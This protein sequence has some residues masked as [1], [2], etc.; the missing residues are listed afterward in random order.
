MSYLSKFALVAVL[1]SGV[2][3]QAA[4][5]INDY[6]AGAATGMDALAPTSAQLL[7]PSAAGYHDYLGVGTPGTDFNVKYDGWSDFTNVTLSNVTLSST[8][9]N[10]QEGS[11][12]AGQ[13]ANFLRTSGGHFVASGGLYSFSSPSTFSVS[14]T[15][16]I[17]DVSKVFFE[18]VITSDA[19]LQEEFGPDYTAL[20][21]GAF[22]ELSLNSGSGAATVA[23]TLVSSLPGGSLAI[24][25]GAPVGG[26]AGLTSYLFSWDLAGYDDVTDFAVTFGLNTHVS[27]IEAALYQ[28]DAT[29]FA[30]SPTT[31]AVPEPATASLLAL[32]GLAVLAR[33][34]R[35][36]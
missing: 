10:A 16:V 34:R 15:N 31:S 19:D 24:P 12:T 26:D 3:A 20:L 27:V 14:D 11:H 7:D 36:A 13:A 9:I 33:R 4:V 6:G 23:A 8:G 21:G 29:E 32:G 1:G 22:P 17:D 35:R 18:M 30:S 2:A 28:T 25:G 5:T